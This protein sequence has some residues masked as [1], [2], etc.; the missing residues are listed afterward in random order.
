MSKFIINV[1]GNYEPSNCRW[2]SISEQNANRTNNHS[3]TY[4]GE[5]HTIAE[6]ARITGISENALYNRAYRNWDLERM[7]TQSVRSRQ[8]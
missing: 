5:T 8:K 6:W 2:I 1:D 7:F 4:N 3:V